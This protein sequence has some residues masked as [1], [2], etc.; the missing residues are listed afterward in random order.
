M[1]VEYRRR[2]QEG[3]ERTTITFPPANLRLLTNERYLGSI[4]TNNATAHKETASRV[5]KASVVYHKLSVIWKSGSLKLKAKLALFRSLVISVLLYGMEA[6]T[7][8]KG[9]ITQ[10]ERFQNRRLRRIAKMQAYSE[11]AASNLQVQVRYEQPS[12][13]SQ[14][15]RRRLRLLQRVLVGGRSKAAAGRLFSA[16]CRGNQGGRP[17]GV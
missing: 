17:P 11:S 6:R 5:Q 3:A 15:R 16:P 1:K 12:I 7:L 8:T 4:F 2:V 13:E 9:N 14:L 10:M